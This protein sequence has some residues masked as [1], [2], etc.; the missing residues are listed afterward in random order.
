MPTLYITDKKI[1]FL[2]VN[3]KRIYFAALL[4]CQL[5][6]PPSTDTNNY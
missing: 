2:L 1:S 5:S 3:T 4:K 6:S